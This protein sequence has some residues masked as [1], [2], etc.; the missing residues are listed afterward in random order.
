[1][2]DVAVDAIALNVLDP[3]AVT[4]N[5]PGAAE[6]VGAPRDTFSDGVSAFAREVLDEAS[7]NEFAHRAST[8]EVIQYTSSHFAL[9]EQVVRS[10]GKVPKKKSRLYVVGR[11]IQVPLTAFMG[12]SFSLTMANAGGGWPILFGVSIA[13]V[14]ALTAAIY[15]Y[16]FVWEQR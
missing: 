16:E 14:A 1:M 8:S 15:I 3:N 6:V 9:A 10:R 5:V 11:I 12:W 13:L 2:S 4:V 7:K